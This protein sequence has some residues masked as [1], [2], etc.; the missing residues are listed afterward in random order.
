MSR[1]VFPIGAATAIAARG[2]VRLDG[3]YSGLA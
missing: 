3:G 1:V 2:V